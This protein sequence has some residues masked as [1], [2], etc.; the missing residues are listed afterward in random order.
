MLNYLDINEIV[1]SHT[2]NFG[3]DGTAVSRRSKEVTIRLT[4]VET[5]GDIALIHLSLPL[6]STYLSPSHYGCRRKKCKVLLGFIEL[7]VKRLE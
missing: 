3:C 1:N 2:I 5:G 4:G 7:I 6:K